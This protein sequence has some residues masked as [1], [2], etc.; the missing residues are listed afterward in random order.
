MGAAGVIESI[1]AI[2]SLNEKLVPQVLG[3]EAATKD[4]AC[5]LNTPI[6]APLKA[7]IRTVLKTSYG[8]GGTNAAVVLASA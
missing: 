2:H 8:F 6:G 5:N 1:A 4:P 3:L 7:D